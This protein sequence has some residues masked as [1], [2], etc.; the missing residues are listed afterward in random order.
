MKRSKR[1]RGRM[2]SRDSSRRSRK[3][4]EERRRLLAAA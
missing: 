1:T 2:M 4:D 3:W